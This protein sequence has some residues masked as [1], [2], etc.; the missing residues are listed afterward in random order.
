MEA[1]KIINKWQI[2]AGSVTNASSG[3]I[4]DTS[5]TGGNEPGRA[6]LFD[7]PEWDALLGE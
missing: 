2:L 3:G 1:I 7:G 4:L 5:V 6:P